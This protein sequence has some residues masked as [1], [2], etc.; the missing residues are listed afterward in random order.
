[1]VIAN[2]RAFVR[3]SNSNTKLEKVYGIRDQWF[4]GYS[5]H[6]EVLCDVIRRLQLPQRFNALT[7]TE[8]RYLMLQEREFGKDL[9]QQ[10][11]Q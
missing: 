1:L 6:P 2:P 4:P 11:L 5:F 8:A 9:K 7:W 3:Y 10:W